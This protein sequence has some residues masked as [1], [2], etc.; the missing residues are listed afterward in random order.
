VGPGLEHSNVFAGVFRNVDHLMGYLPLFSGAGS[1]MDSWIAGRDGSWSLRQGDTVLHRGRH[2]VYFD[3]AVPRGPR[4][5]VLR[6]SS[7]PTAPDWDLSTRVDDVWSFQSQAGQRPALL[8]PS[9][10]PPSTMTGY[11]SPGRTS[12]PLSFD[13]SRRV[14]GARLLLSTDGGHTWAPAR[15]SRLARDAFRVSYTNPGAHGS[16]AFMSMKVTGR[17]A[18]GSTVTETALNVYRLR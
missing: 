1:G 18:Q 4:R 14:T 17:D 6:A 5:Y 10:V 8:T 15:L 16:H 13:T 2:E 3:V 11:V 12:F 9:Y 7:H